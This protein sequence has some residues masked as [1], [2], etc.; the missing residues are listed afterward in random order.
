MD[1]GIYFSPVDPTIYQDITARNSFGKGIQIYQDSFP[2]IEAADIAIVGLT[3]NR[4]AG[5]DNRGIAQAADAVRKALYRL[6]KG[7]GDYKIADLGNLR[8]GPDL[9]ETC[10]RIKAICERLISVNTLPVLIG[11]SHDLDYGQFQGYENLEKLINVLSVDAM[12]DIEANGRHSAGRHSAGRGSPPGHSANQDEKPMLP[13]RNHLHKMLVHDPN[14]LLHYS[15]LAY[16]SFLVDKTAPLVLEKF[17]F[18]AYR[19]G[20]ISQDINA[21]EPVIRNADMISFDISAIQSSDAPG[22]TNA[23]PFGLTGQDACQLCWYAGQSERLSS[24]GFYEYNPEEDDHRNKTAAVIA[25][26][27]WYVVEGF[28]NKK[29]EKGFTSTGYIKYIVP[30]EA[31]PSVITFYKSKLSE[32]WWMEVPHPP[33]GA[34]KGR[35]SIVPCDPIDYKMAV[36]GEVPDRWIQTYAKF[37]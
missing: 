25:T 4:G 16:Q 30:M 12:I 9:D 26:M 21:M 29:D 27:I 3:E 15:H 33:T 18:D 37:T 35:K 14:Y 5:E 36:K 17:Y 1:L 13:H 34:V 2:D 22:N 31:D 19:F 24:I 23:Q 28:Y 11:G 20:R 32:K 6:K 8:N 10:L 7:G